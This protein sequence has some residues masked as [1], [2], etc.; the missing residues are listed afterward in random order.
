MRICPKCGTE[1]EKRFCP[2]CGTEY[3]EPM[4]TPAQEAVVETIPEA[5]GEAAPEAA[6]EPAVEPAAPEAPAPEACDA[7]ELEVLTLQHFAGE[8]QYSQQKTVDETISDMEGSMSAKTTAIVAY[9]TWVGFIIALV[10]GDRKNAMF[11]INQALV[12]NLAAI[13]FNILSIVPILGWLAAVIGN[14]FCIVCWCMGLYYAA[15]D[16]KKEVPLLGQIKLL[17]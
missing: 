10:L 14:I 6:V 11:H 12:I 2:D 17:S 16:Q 7:K 1:V 8:E 5:V 15:T 4:E 3:V 9:I 13:V